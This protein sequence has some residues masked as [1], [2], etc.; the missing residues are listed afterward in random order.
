MSLSSPSVRV[1]LVPVLLLA[2]GCFVKLT[3]GPRGPV[4]KTKQASVA[5]PV[6]NPVAPPPPAKPQRSLEELEKDPAYEYYFRDK[7]LF[8]S[9]M[10]R[11]AVFASSH[12]AARLAVL[13]FFPRV[14]TKVA[15]ERLQAEVKA[16]FPGV[17]ETSRLRVH[18]VVDPSVPEEMRPALDQQL[19]ASERALALVP[20]APGVP[21]LTLFVDGPVSFKDEESPTWLKV[22]GGKSF[23]AEEHVRTASSTVRA[24]WSDTARQAPPAE[25]FT[26]E[27]MDRYF[28]HDAQPKLGLAAEH[29]RFLPPEVARARHFTHA[30]ELLAA[31]VVELLAARDAASAAPASTASPEAKLERLMREF[32]RQPR[33]D[34]D[35]ARPLQSA[36]NEWMAMPVPEAYAS[37]VHVSTNSVLKEGVARCEFDGRAPEA[38]P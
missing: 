38:G 10:E 26:L 31:K 9:A 16:L 24:V 1:L 3:A 14:P 29:G 18:L 36:L 34:N 12:P 30:G 37:W 7:R 20:A 8:D 2:Q 5:K 6:A 32:L 19:K 25:K 28:D 15:L 17:S 4:A 27:T 23:Y 35:A 22:K 33:M 11:S 13:L 21:T